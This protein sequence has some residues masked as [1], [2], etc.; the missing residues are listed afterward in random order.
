MTATNLADFQLR[1]DTF[2]NKSLPHKNWDHINL[3][4]PS[5]QIFRICHGLYSIAH[6]EPEILSKHQMTGAMTFEQGTLDTNIYNL[7]YKITGDGYVD[8]LQMH[9]QVQGSLNKDINCN[10]YTVMFFTGLLRAS[11]RASD[12]D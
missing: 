11:E 9:L 8:L 6:Q 4:A 10:Y 5:E 1:W 3:Q 12:D 7:Q 2:I